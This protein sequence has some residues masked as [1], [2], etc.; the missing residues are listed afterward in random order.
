MVS[1][2]SI[3]YP[4]SGPKENYQHEV[5]VPEDERRQDCVD[6]EDYIWDE[7]EYMEQEYVEGRRCYPVFKAC[8]KDEPT[9]LSKDKVRVFQAA[10]VSLQLLV[11]KYYLPIVRAMSMLPLAS[12]CAVGVNAH[13]REWEQ[14]STRIT[15]FGKD[16]ILAG[17]YSKYDLRMPSQ[18]V[19][20]AF[21]VLVDI[22]AKCG[23][24]ARDLG[25][26]KGIATD[27]AYPVMAYNGDLI[28]LYASNP[29]GHNLTV[30]INCIVNSLLLRC[31]YYHV[32]DP[33]IPFRDRVAMITYGDDCKGSVSVE[34]EYYNHISVAKYL[35][36]RGMVFTM[37]DKEAT[38]RPFMHDGE[39]DFLKRFS[40][41]HEKL[42]CT[43]GALDNDSIYKSL[44]AVL[45]SPFL[46]PRQQAMA[47]LETAAAEWF[48]H[49]EAVY[50]T[51]RQQLL[52]I[53]RIHE[54]DCGCP[55]LK[56]SYDD[57]VIQW[58]ERY[59]DQSL[60]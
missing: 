7:F 56:L 37:P 51:K 19:L 53:A 27:I 2:T 24:C 30:Y 33:E 52:A 1:G 23:Y 12:E 3:G 22:A 21:S 34:C 18:L 41:Y 54:M 39:A 4:L 45:K 35:S 14:L 32:E 59:P 48:V 17:D 38:P 42:N 9:P 47:N 20:A 13:S 8:L 36:D 25:I 40:V 31:A 29:S 58:K 55:S 43:L 57:R 10:P 16:R 49:G 60:G 28:S 15:Q 50:E 6:F 11:R 26:M 44:H 46:S 5:V